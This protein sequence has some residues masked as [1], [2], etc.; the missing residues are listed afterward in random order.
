VKGAEK[1]LTAEALQ[2]HL[3]K[4]VE[5]G[6]IT[7]WAVPEHYLFLDEMPKTS[8]GKIDKKALRKQYAESPKG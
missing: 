4:Y 7:K 5:E 6:I 1:W 2:E 8:V 3:Q